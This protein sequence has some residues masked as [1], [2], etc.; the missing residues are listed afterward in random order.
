MLTIVIAIVRQ[1]VIVSFPIAKQTEIMMATE[2]TL[3]ASKKIENIFEFLIFLTKGLSKATNTKEGR[4]IP[5]VETIAPVSP[6]I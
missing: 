6:L 3:T 5:I 2:A 4:K 1:S